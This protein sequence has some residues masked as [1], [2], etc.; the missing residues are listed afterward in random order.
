MNKVTSNSPGDTAKARFS[1][2]G[3]LFVLV[4]TG[5]SALILATSWQI[6]IEAQ[7]EAQIAIERSL[8]QSSVILETKLK[9]RS[10]SIREIAKGLARDGRVFPLVYEGESLTL[11]DL[12]I[13]FEKVLEFD[14]VFFTDDEGTIL[15]RSDRPEAIGQSVAGRSVLFDT[16][17]DGRD[18][19]G[20]IS[21]QGTL[22]Q[23]VVVPIFDNFAQD[24][25]RGT[26]A[27][28]YTL[29]PEMAEEIY[30]LTAA[31]IGFFMFTRDEQRQVDAVK[32][33]YNTNEVLG[34]ILETWFNGDRGN[35]Q[36]LLTS[37]IPVPDLRV[38]LENDDIVAVAYPLAGSRGENLGFVLASQSQTQLMEPFFRIQRQVIVVGVICLVLSS[39]FAWVLATRISRPII[40]LVRVAK[41]IQEGHYPEQKLKHEQNDEVDV[42]FNAVHHM[43]NSLKEKAELETYLAQL[44]EDLDSTEEIVS[45]ETDPL[46]D[47][48][49]AEPD[50]ETLVVRTP[51]FSDDISG[52]ATIVSSPANP[53]AKPASAKAV[54]EGHIHAGDTIA[55]RYKIAKLLG[56]GAMGEVYL[57]KDIDLDENIAIKILS[58]KEFAR[59]E[60]H[61]FKEEIRLARRITHRNILRT[62]DYGFWQKNYYITME[63][64]QGHDLGKFIE[65]KG[66]LEMGIGLAMAKQICSAM[67]AAHEEGIIHRDLKPANMMINRQGILKI[68]DFG[69]AMKVGKMNGLN[70]QT[71][72][73]NSGQGASSTI[74]GT[75][76]YMAPEQFYGWELDQRTDIY[77][78]G[79]ILYTLF[80]GRPPFKGKTV[81]EFADLHTNSQAPDLGKLVKGFPG[82]LKDIIIKA[83]EK[84]PADRFDTVRQMLDSLQSL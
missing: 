74:A 81:E 44:G 21:I 67:N 69:L 22:L 75:P 39:L 34:P 25:V 42:L 28:A 37:K 70:N 48:A 9:S 68:M 8:G 58:K 19:S 62:F 63:F 18:A 66:R 29:S 49:L 43:G 11:Q 5:F 56:V 73:D 78:I 76:K 65:R 50:D 14:I 12:S 72:A 59:E 13:E 83:I 79:I 41:N 52:E 17:L 53:S 84:K 77:S 24:I 23:T 2:R 38:S 55:D 31:E 27:L 1:I 20:I 71:E 32:S 40:D 60:T 15:A 4:L 16:A 46:P 33:T 80:S 10:D 7:S 45:P 82:P 57:A 64:V 3:K 30:S 54:S 36:S 35:W 26:V 6:G 51:T 61:Q 47:E